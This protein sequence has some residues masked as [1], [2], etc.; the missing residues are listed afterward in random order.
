MGDVPTPINNVATDINNAIQIAIFDVALNALKA[1]AVAS[2]PWLGWPIINQLFNLLTNLI[3][4]YVYTYL[5][6]I[7]TF[8]VIDMQTAA[9]TQAYAQA[10]NAL[11]AAMTTG[12]QNAIGQATSEVK[13]ALAAL[14]HFDGSASLQLRASQRLRKGS[15]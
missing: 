13:T 3:G 11:Q 8:T 7:A 2:L 9:E 1:Y 15:N 4:K 6:Q 5:A 14:I 12:D 10:L